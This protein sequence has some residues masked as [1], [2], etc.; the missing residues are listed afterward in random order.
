[1]VDEVDELAL[2][3]VEPDVARPPGQPEFSI[4]IVRTLSRSAASASSRSPV[5]SVEPSSTKIS[6]YSAAGSDCPSSDA[7]SGSM[8][9]PGSKTGTMTD[10]LT[11]RAGTIEGDGRPATTGGGAQSP[12]GTANT[13]RALT[14]SLPSAWREQSAKAS[15]PPT[16][17]TFACASI[18][19]P[20]GT[21]R[22]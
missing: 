19:A 9:S 3:G 10:T 6:S 2:R 11:I 17:S 8:R 4:R 18:H 14:A 21:G 15:P 22:M 7:S 5:P 1:M 13:A 20:G 12:S 16:R